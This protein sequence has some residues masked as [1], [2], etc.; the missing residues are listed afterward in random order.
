M[1]KQDSAS[2]TRWFALL[3]TTALVLI[4]GAALVHAIQGGFNPGYVSHPTDRQYPVAG[5]LT[6]CGFITAEAGL[7]FAI[8]RPFSL[9]DYRRVLIALVIFVSLWVVEFFL[10]SGWTDQAGYCYSNG[11]F[12]SFSVCFL[13]V[14]AVLSFFMFPRGDKQ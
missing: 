11:F 3:M 7:L 2:R 4:W 5:V 13:G 14:A 6:V 10:I 1:S 8:L 9:S 12:L